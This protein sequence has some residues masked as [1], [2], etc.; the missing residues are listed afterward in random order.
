MRIRKIAAIILVLEM[1]VTV[2]LLLK[3]GVF[4][5]RVRFGLLERREARSRLDVLKTKPALLPA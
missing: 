3:G 2:I 5:G 4:G 1:F